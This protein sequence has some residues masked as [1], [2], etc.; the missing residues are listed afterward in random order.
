MSDKVTSIMK[1]E[2]TLCA[3]ARAAKEDRQQ[4]I[5]SHERL[6]ADAMNRMEMRDLW[7]Q[8]KENRKPTPGEQ[9]IA[10]EWRLD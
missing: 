3:L 6:M 9:A 5:T 8:I 4:C 10:A 1:K 2:W 7:Q